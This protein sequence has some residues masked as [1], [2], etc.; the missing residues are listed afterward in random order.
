[1]I[2]WRQGLKRYLEQLERNLALTKCYGLGRRELIIS[3]KFRNTTA[4]TGVLRGP[5]VFR[6]VRSSTKTGLSPDRTVTQRV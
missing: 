1:M 6:N 3:I 4:A 2:T 5:G